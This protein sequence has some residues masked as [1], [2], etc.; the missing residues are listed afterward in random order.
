MVQNPANMSLRVQNFVE[1]VI[2]AMRAVLNMQADADFAK[3]MDGR[4]PQRKP[5]S[6]PKLLIRNPLP[7]LLPKLL[8]RVSIMGS[9]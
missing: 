2:Y 1:V 8:L 5:F 4:L 7:R 3:W 9:H 6:L